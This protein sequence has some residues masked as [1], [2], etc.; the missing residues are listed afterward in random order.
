MHYVV[1]KITDFWIDR[2]KVNRE[3]GSYV[4]ELTGWQY[5]DPHPNSNPNP[6]SDPF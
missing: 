2:S 4:D 3:T 5:E 6:L 1:K